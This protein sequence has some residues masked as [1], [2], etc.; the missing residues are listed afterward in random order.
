MTSDG[1]RKAA[2]Q[3]RAWVQ[4]KYP[5]DVKVV[6]E[7]TNP[8]R[9]SDFIDGYNSAL[10]EIEQVAREAFEAGQEYERYNLYDF[11]DYWR[12]K[13]ESKEGE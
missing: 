7:V 3:A 2:E 11:D 12:L 4:T 10:R 8:E 9:E 5:S 13:T 1:D 6:G